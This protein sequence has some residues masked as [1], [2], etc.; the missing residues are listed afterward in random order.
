MVL[1]IVA[2]FCSAAYLLYFP[3]DDRRRAAQKRL[4]RELRRQP[5]NNWKF[6]DSVT[7]IKRD[8]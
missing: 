3:A 2:L 6:D 7:I 4:L 5:H 1:L 8:Q